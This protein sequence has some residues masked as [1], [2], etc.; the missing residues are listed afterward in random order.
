[1]S[2]ILPTHPNFENY[3]REHDAVLDMLGTRVAKIPLS[4]FFYQRTLV[5]ETRPTVEAYSRLLEHIA[6]DYGTFREHLGYEPELDQLLAGAPSYP[7]NVPIGR[8]DLFLTEDGPRIVEVNTESAGGIEENSYLEELFLRHFPEAVSGYKAHARL[9]QGINALVSSYQEQKRA[10]GR[11]GE[12]VEKPRIVLFKA[13]K[14]IKRIRGEVE[15]FR[16]A[17]QQL[18]Y[19][20]E[21]LPLESATFRDGHLYAQGRVVD[22]VYRRFILDR[23]PEE[24]PEG[25]DFARRLNDSSVALVNP[26][27]SKRVSSKRVQVLLSDPAYERLFPPRLL[28]DLKRVRK[29]IP[30]TRDLSRPDSTE[31]L[32]REMLKDRER[33][34]IKAANSFASKAV[35]IGSD[36]SPEEWERVAKEAVGADFILQ[37]RINLPRVQVAVLEEGSRLEQEMIFNVCPYMFRGEFGGFYVR[38]SDDN[39]TSF[40]EGSLATVL[41]C[42]ERL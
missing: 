21:I 19:D 26:V 5:D 15:V 16:I 22:L 7:H 23:L 1:M 9:S 39:L 8:I 28:Q 17:A 33:L 34:V 29:N 30:R 24:H 42:F 35:F 27:A 6:G 3:V 32:L 10:K 2:L 4:P 13:A 20:C 38:A 25:F 37:E 12:I 36:I 40:K 11:E 41:P 18:G 31:R 14:E